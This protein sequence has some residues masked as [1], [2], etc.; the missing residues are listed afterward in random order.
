M[1]P[2]AGHTTAAAAGESA[3]EISF[4]SFNGF[5]EHMEWA[6]ISF[7]VHYV[8]LHLEVELGRDYLTFPSMDWPEQVI[9]SYFDFEV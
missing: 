3:K 5:G 6:S 9:F 7:R 1:R 4:L 8:L 2:G